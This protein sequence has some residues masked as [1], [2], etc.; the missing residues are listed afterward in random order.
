MFLTQTVGTLPLAY[1]AQWRSLN[2]IIVYIL[3]NILDP[4]MSFSFVFAMT[5][6]I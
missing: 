1:V 4:I 5:R 2:L 3:V 6:I